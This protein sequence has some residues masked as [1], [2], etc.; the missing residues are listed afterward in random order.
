MM[1]HTAHG[2]EIDKKEPGEGARRAQTELE[3]FD[4]LRRDHDS[5]R[6]LFN[7][8]EKTSNKEI[9]TRQELFTQLE[10]QLLIH[11]E[12]EER[13]LYTAL[14]RYDESRPK[15]LEGY[16]EHLVARTIIGAFISLA[17]DD[18]RWAAKLKVLREL[19]RHHMDEEEHDLFKVAKTVLGKEQIQGITAKVQ[20]LKREAKKG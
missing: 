13:F 9:E 8:I 20:D 10:Q 4:L 14:E 16:E 15:A 3:L 19:V 2:K 17:V 18:E 1:A 7:R 5:A 6:D 12:A 11:M